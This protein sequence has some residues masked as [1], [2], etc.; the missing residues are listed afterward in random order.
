M[1]AVSVVIPTYNRWSQLLATLE[2]LADQTVDADEVEIIVVSDGST[3]ETN[4][5]LRAGDAPVDVVFVEQDNQG[6]AVARN[7]GIQEASADLVL[8]ID[9]DVVPKP[10]CVAAHLRAHAGLDADTVVVGPLLGPAGWQG[11]PWVRW[12]QRMLDRQY[13]HMRRGDWDA[14]ARQFYTGNASLVRARLVEAG[15]FS[16][17]FRRGEDVELAYR[18]A[19][20]GM[21]FVVD[22]D[23]GALHYAERTYRSWLSNAKAYGANDVT[24]WRQG[25][26]WLVPTVTAEYRSRNALVRLY[27]TAGLRFRPLQWVGERLAAPLASGLSL[28]GLDR[29]SDY[30]LSAI[31]NLAYYRSFSDALGDDAPNE[32]V[33]HRPRQ[34]PATIL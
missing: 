4:A 31:Y 34:P 10:G 18:L 33:G 6:P 30:G 26:S 19:R 24:M 21:R 5:R 16:A 17:T 2:G 3:D 7:R 9:D 25:E 22:F 20:E 23:A 28:V 8:F 12:E 15:G 1:T 11:S 13:E 14:T 32:F 29:L 27:T